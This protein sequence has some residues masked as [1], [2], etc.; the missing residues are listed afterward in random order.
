MAQTVQYAPLDQPITEMRK[1]AHAWD[2]FRPS[3]LVTQ[4]WSYFFRWTQSLLTVAPQVIGTVLLT[5]Q[6]A[7]IS[8][9]TIP[10]T[11]PA[12]PNERLLPGLYRVSYYARITRAAS[13]SSELIV[14]IRWVDGGVTITLPGATITA[15]TTST[16]Q[17]NTYLVR[18]DSETQLSYLTSYTSVGGTTM[19]YRLDIR[20]E[21]VPEPVEDP[22]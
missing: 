10:T 14:S 21:A 17:T 3:G 22:A 11:F 5:T 7:A 8:A 12:L 15:N 6:S 20:V 4:V 16:I 19:Q 2:Q 13:T 1:P 18:V 9:T